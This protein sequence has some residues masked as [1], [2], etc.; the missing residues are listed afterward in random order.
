MC[1]DF[2]G[3]YS[4]GSDFVYVNDFCYYRNCLYTHRCKFSSDIEQINESQYIVSHLGLGLDP[5][6]GSDRDPGM[7]GNVSVFPLF[8]FSLIF[9]P[10]LLFSHLPN[11]P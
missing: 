9:S 10:F 6:F 2:H 1:I 7:T 3:H 11:T 5:P 4:G 8:L